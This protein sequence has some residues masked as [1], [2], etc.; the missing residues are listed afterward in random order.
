[1][2]YST[3]PWPNRTIAEDLQSHHRVE[4]LRGDATRGEIVDAR[5]IATGHLIYARRGTLEAVSFDAEALKLTGAPAAVIGDVMQ[6]LGGG[7]ADLDTGM[8]Q[9]VVSRTGT[10]FYVPGGVVP[11]VSSR[12][13]W[14][15]LSG[16]RDV[17]TELTEYVDSLRIS[18]DGTRVALTT[19]SNPGAPL[20]RLATLDLK[21]NTLMSVTE[22]DGVAAYPIWTPDGRRLTFAYTARPAEEPV[23]N[24]FTMPADQVTQPERLTRSE[25]D[26]FP[27]SWTP[28]GGTLVYDEQPQPIRD[29]LWLLRNDSGRGLSEPLL[30]TDDREMSAQVSPDGRWLAYQFRRIT[31]AEGQATGSSQ[32]VYVRP[33]SRASAGMRV[34]ID[35]GMA[36]AWA[37]DGHTMYYTRLRRDAP[38][39]KSMI[40][41]EMADGRPAPGRPQREI[42]SGAWFSG[43][44]FRSYD[45]AP[46][47]KRFLFP[48]DVS[49]SRQA[50]SHIQVVVN[51]TE[52][53]RTR[54]KPGK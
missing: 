30:Q 12:L 14:R 20:A 10:L 45:L 17:L 18:P 43:N 33:L 1:V 44:P 11:P 27:Q 52:E 35:N 8:M 19:A 24:L 36:P 7:S 26:Q 16:R 5:Y 2:L 38:G 40:A 13:V 22:A 3:D 48:E 29:D 9:A 15:D 47:G 6:S 23:L 21:T 34:S 42:F 50:V 41:V 54:V 4:L 46:D 37:P 53:L 51:W 39:V 28:D 31:A 49:P 25:H 32:H